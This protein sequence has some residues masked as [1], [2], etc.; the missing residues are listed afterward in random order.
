VETK[1]RWDNEA[2]RKLLLSTLFFAAAGVFSGTS[3]A[4]QQSS[5]Q[6]PA[7]PKSAASPQTAGAAKT[8]QGTAA[9]KKPGAATAAP[10]I[11]K[12]DKDKRSYAIGL[13]IGGKVANELKAGGVDMD[14]AVLARGI[15]DS[16]TG[17]KHLMTDE[18][19]KTTL[20]ALETE[21]REKARADYEAM[22]SANKKQG[23]DFLAANKS[24]EGVQALPSG[25][26]YKVLK[27]GTG[28]KPAGT[29]KVSCNYKGTFLDGKEFDS[30]EKHGGKPV[31]FGVSE[32][33][34][35]WTEALQLMPVGS[36]WQLF[37]PSDL[38]Y[39]PRGAGQEIGPNT[40]LIFEVEL[41]SIEPKAEDKAD[42][43][44]PAANPEAAK[45]EAKPNSN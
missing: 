12:T 6:A 18:E 1:V 9:A 25:L 10:A 30:S 45:P 11:L 24:K 40:A 22:A 31:R 5:T 16:L 44:K 7:A 32:V 42:A 17:A 39:G 29:D 20:T 41:V 23:D 27:A 33:I 34:K 13:N 35:A 19:V 36:K 28:P 8:A 14:S 4:A 3:A 43:A 15:R 37:V 2:M 21:L 38:A 26:Q